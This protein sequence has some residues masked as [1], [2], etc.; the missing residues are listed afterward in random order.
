MPVG[1]WF[2]T[3]LTYLG[4]C[5][6][7]RVI[8]LLNAAVNYLEVGRWMREKGFAAY[9]RFAKRE[10]VFDTM[11]DLANGQAVLYLEFG[12][13]EGESIR[14]WSNLL[15]NPCSHLH[16]FDSFAGLPDSWNLDNVKGTFSTDGNIPQIP[17]PRVEFFKGWFDETLRNYE[18]PA[19]EQLIINC[20]ADLYESTASVLKKFES[21]IVP[22][23][24]IYFDEFSDRHHELKAFDEFID[25]TKMKFEVIGADRQLSRVAFRRVD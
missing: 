10:S 21:R 23:T 4:A 19:Y 14:Y 6:P 17:D 12:V 11:A 1:T 22:G 18:P 5:L 3:A 24:L 2:K 16:G 20:D 8:H 25:R 15:K 9:P 13:F 7:R